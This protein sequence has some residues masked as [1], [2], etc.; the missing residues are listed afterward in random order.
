VVSRQSARPFLASA[1]FSWATLAQG[2]CAST[3]AA[4]TPGGTPADPKPTDEREFHCARAIMDSSSPYRMPLAGPETDP[5]LVAHLASLPYK[6]RR[7]ALA[8]GLEPLLARLLAA[9]DAAAGASTVEALAL[10]EELTLRLVAFHA[11]LSAAAFE[12]GCTADMIQKLLPEFTHRE[13][14]RQ[15]TITIASLVVGAVSSIAAGFWTLENPSSRGPAVVGIA[16][17][18]ATTAL[19]VAALTHGE[20]SIRFEHARNR[21][22]PLWRG[23]DPDHLYPS[24]VFRMLTYPDTSEGKSPRDQLLASWQLQLERSVPAVEQAAARERLLG[25]GG[26]Y[27]EGLLTLR[28]E[29]FESLESMIQGLARDLELLNRSLVRSLTALAPPPP[30]R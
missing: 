18:A 10:E 11:Q 16:G 12:A 24:F 1:L 14:S 28:A 4:R 22:V 13:Q 29:M 5:A 30:A 2:A 17:G 8:A 23:A 15:L 27:D 6:A 21:L 25:D 7:A 26:S 3:G 20:R 9:R 19:G